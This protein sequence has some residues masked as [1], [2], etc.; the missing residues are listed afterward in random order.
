MS[1]LATTERD[2]YLLNFPSSSFGLGW[3]VL[4]SQ[5]TQ[6]DEVIVKRI[7]TVEVQ[8]PVPRPRQHDRGN[9]AQWGGCTMCEADSHL[10]GERKVLEK[11]GES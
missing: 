8:L 11:E 5:A 10:L 9:K 4:I 2:I 1:S 7:T 3:R 6:A